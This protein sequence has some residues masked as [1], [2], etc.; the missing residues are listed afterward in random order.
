MEPIDELNELPDPL[1]ERTRTLDARPAGSPSVRIGVIGAGLSGLVAAR[2]LAGHGHTVRVFEKS[3]GLG[4]RMATRRKGGYAFDHGAQYFTAR[5]ERFKKWVERWID[6]GVVRLWEGRIRVVQNGEIRTEAG[7]H[8]RYVAVPGMSALAG[9][10]AV[11]LEVLKG[12]RIERIRPDSGGIVLMDMDG[13]SL[14]RCDALICSAPPEQSE[15]LLE[16][17]APERDRL[18]GIDMAPCWAVMLAFDR[19]LDLPFDGAFVQDSDLSW[20][21]RNSSKPG[22]E[23]AECWILHAGW[24]WSSANFE[25]N[26]EDVVR[27]LTASFFAAAGG[28]S[29]VPVFA[30]AHRWRYAL[31]RAPL[32]EGCLWNHKFRVGVCGDWCSGS[33]IEGAFLSGAAVAARVLSSIS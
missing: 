7:S 33:R 21:A 27:R 22:R 15:R 4:G 23:A 31:A 28:S 11:G 32:T 2:M 6:S 1:R 26:A 17:L 30:D 12:V 18:A 8:K 19:H 13:R 10:L 20:V 3:R 29:I 25:C 9:H 5:D 14:Y 16:D 24:K